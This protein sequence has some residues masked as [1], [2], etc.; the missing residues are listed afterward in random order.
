MSRSN[1][2]FIWI[3]R[4]ALV[5]V[6][7]LLAMRLAPAV[8]A[9]WLGVDVLRGLPW[10]DIPTTGLGYFLYDISCAEELRGA[11]QSQPALQVVAGDG[12]LRPF[13]AA[14]CGWPQPAAAPGAPGVRRT[15]L[16]WQLGRLSFLEGQ[17]D[18]ALRYWQ[19]APG[20][21]LYLAKLGADQY[22]RN[23]DEADAAQR[24][25]A[26]SFLLLAEQVN[27]QVHPDKAAAY[28]ALYRLYRDPPL[29][30]PEQALSY[31]R[32]LLQ[33]DP[34][35]ANY[36]NVANL[37]LGQEDYA[38]ALTVLRELQ[39]TAPQYGQ[40]FYPLGRAYR[41]LGDLPAALASLQR[42]PQSANNYPLV[43]AEMAEIMFAQG[44]AQA[45]GDLA[46]AALASG[47][48]RAARQ[49]RELLTQLEK[50]E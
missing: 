24:A 27:P 34:Q 37:L 40:A 33:V 50:N 22:W 35:P 38:G 48:D 39:Q 10:A 14:I 45:A 4:L 13:A 16:D 47:N 7:A 23:R 46:R 44:D 43:Q 21:D 31:A 42:V 3:S 2:S 29:R 17:A 11:L 25:Q 32:K 18:Q 36:L 1:R 49:A 28:E 26:L 8:Q 5:I 41:G 9:N 12:A 15:L 6:L 30:D 19:A 20:A